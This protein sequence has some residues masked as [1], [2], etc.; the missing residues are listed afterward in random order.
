MSS[1]IWRRHSTLFQL[2]TRLSDLEVLTLITGTLL[3]E[4]I[5]LYINSHH[6]WNYLCWHFIFWNEICWSSVRSLI[7]IIYGWTSVE[8]VSMDFIQFCVVQRWDVYDLWIL[9][10]L[11]PVRVGG[12]RS[13]NISEHFEVFILIKR[14][15][16]IALPPVF[17]GG[18]A[19][20]G[21][22]LT[23]FPSEIR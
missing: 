22:N 3:K 4:T 18:A 16:D 8:C 5:T 7:D 12:W 19:D 13:H 17:R 14:G 1:P 21:I 11:W 9:K 20:R 15:W 23:S 10:C 2:T 6:I